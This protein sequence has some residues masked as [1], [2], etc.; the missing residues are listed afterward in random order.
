MDAEGADGCLCV[1]ICAVA[2]PAGLPGVVLGC[3]VSCWVPG[4][5]LGASCCQCRAPG[6]WLVWVLLAVRWDVGPGRGLQAAASSQMWPSSAQ[7]GSGV[8]L[9][10]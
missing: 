8:S 2:V 6:T 3:Q 7:G 4:V 1:F 5:V 10:Q 9:W